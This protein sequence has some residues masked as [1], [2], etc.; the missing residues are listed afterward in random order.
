MAPHDTDQLL[1]R[2]LGND[3]QTATVRL[4]AGALVA[5]AVVALIV[6]LL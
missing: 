5:A 2:A 4:V 6:K 1:A 3:L